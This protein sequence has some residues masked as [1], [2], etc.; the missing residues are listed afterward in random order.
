MPYANYARGEKVRSTGRL[1]GFAGSRAEE[2][3]KILITA[4]ESEIYH[5]RLILIAIMPRACV[6]GM[7]GGK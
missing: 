3:S 1:Y 4:F 7:D 6:V 5:K 2:L